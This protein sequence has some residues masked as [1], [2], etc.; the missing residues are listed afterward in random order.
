MSGPKILWVAHIRGINV[1]IKSAKS[2][3]TSF[4]ESMIKTLAESLWSDISFDWK[5]SRY[6][7]EIVTVNIKMIDKKR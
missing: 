3:I 7:G 6:I 4:S 1:R 5:I 2:A